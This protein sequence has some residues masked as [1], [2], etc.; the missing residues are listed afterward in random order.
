MFRKV[1]F[2][3]VFHFYFLAEDFSHNIV[4]FMMKLFRHVKNITLE[5]TVSQISYLGPSS[6]FI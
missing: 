4:Y 5:G 6:Y 1:D 2:N 3:Q